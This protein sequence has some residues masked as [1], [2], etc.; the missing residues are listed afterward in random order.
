MSQGEEEKL[1]SPFSF[2]GQGNSL[3]YRYTLDDV[4]PGCLIC[5]TKILLEESLCVT[6][7][8]EL[9]N[10]SEDHVKSLDGKTKQFLV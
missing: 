3:L 2:L 5:L 10:F 8:H 9:P 7:I 4:E 1:F 6:K